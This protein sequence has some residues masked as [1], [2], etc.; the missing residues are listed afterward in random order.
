M[1]M[2]DFSL[3]SKMTWGQCI[4]ETLAMERLSM[5]AK[6]Q[7]SPSKIP[8]VSVVGF[9]GSGKTTFVEKLIPA[10]TSRGIKVGTI[11]HDVHGF[12]LDQ[13]GKDSWRHRRAGAAVTII[14]SPGQI[15]MV[16]DVDHDLSP[17]ELAQFIS[18]VD[19]ILTEGYKRGP[20]PKV[21]IFRRNAADNQAP[22][23]LD[24]P[25]LLAVV[26]N[27]KISLKVPLFGLD[28]ASGVAE[29]IIRKLSVFPQRR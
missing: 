15:G 1:K 11:K 8:I 4:S 9:S 2:Q 23:C 24:D 27:E 19:L 12:D 3:C 29:L 20:F 14:A 10:L 17:L 13:P 6:E 26:S 21:E 22:V 18:G 28:D 16:K 25:A 7:R 5:P